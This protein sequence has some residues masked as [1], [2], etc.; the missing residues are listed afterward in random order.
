MSNELILKKAIEKAVKNGYIDKD[1]ISLCIDPRN[2]V[3]PGAETILNE[4]LRRPYI[5][6]LIFSHQF[7]KSFWGEK[8]EFAVSSYS[9]TDKDDLY[10]DPD[11]DGRKVYDK[12]ILIRIPSWKYHLQQMVLEENPINYLSK[13]L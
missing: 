3:P 6:D 2:E 12:S 7:A 11:F 1:L 4:L 10:D 8:L 5:I 13:F 9:C